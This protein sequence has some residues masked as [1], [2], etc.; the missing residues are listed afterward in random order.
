ML[1]KIREE[2]KLAMKAGEKQRLSTIRL[3][4]S[5]IKNESI[6][7]RRELEESE[8]LTVVQREVKQRRNAVEEY[9]KG[10]RD[11]LVQE[12]K[13]E[14]AILESYLPQQ[15]SEEEL[16]EMVKHVIDELKATPKE[17][18]KV[19]GKLMPMVK[20]KADGG[21]VQDAVKKLLG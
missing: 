6:E 14:I 15:M 21:R 1:E 19:M 3:L 17:F 4:L 5:A 11:D 16:S 9:I 10:K 7:K 13:E 8:I 18:G 20:G 12:A 2:M